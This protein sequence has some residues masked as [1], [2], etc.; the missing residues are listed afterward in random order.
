MK[1]SS[2]ERWLCLRGPG[3]RCYSRNNKTATAKTFASDG[4]KP[5]GLEK[6]QGATSSKE[7][8]PRGPESWRN[9]SEVV[10]VERQTLDT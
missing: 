9:L 7:R 3:Q 6:I 5:G 4:D 8:S 2:F 1:A 10:T